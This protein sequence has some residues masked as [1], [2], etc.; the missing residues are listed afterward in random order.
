MVD[1]L[2]PSAEIEAGVAVMVVV[3]T[4][5]IPGANAIVASSEIA[6]ELSVPV[7]VAV[8]VIVPAVKIAV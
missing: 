1:V 6:T 8:P 3:D 2:I 7:I 4:L 5:A